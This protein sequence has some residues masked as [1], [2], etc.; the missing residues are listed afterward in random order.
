[1][2]EER[3]PQAGM[4]FERGVFE[5]EKEGRTNLSDAMMEERPSRSGGI[6][7]RKLLPHVLHVVNGGVSM[8]EPRGEEINAALFVCARFDD[9]HFPGNCDG[10]VLSIT[11]SVASKFK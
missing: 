3:T 4:T 7:G 2:N 5:R 8:I 10:G 6:F 11:V 9:D 1:M